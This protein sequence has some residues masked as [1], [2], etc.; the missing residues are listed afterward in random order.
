MLNGQSIIHGHKQTGDRGEG[1][2]PDWY[3]EAVATPFD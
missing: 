1:R 3:P 2:G